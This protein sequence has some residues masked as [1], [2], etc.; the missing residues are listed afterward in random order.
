[1]YSWF[2]LIDEEGIIAEEGRVRTTT[3][4]LTQRF[5]ALPACRIVLEVGT[6]SPWV[7]RLLTD[8]GHEVIVANAREVHLIARSDRKQDRIDA[9]LRARLGR[10]DPHLL[11]PVK[12]RGQQAQEDLA[13]VRSRHSLVLARTTLINHVRGTVKAHGSRLP[14]RAGRGDAQVRP[15]P[16]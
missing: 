1:M 5:R 14:A 4:A 7:S 9:Q 11:A 3:P 8:L 12:H 6:H 16:G 2:C 13:F 10:F 15:P